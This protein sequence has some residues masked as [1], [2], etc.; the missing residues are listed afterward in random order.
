MLAAWRRVFHPSGNDDT[1]S[2]SSLYNEKC[3]QLEINVTESSPPKATGAIKIE[4]VEAVGG[5]KGRYLLYIGYVLP[6]PY[7]CPIQ[8]PNANHLIPFSLVMLM[9]IL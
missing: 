7:A 2:P 9:V 6:Q 5:R 8:I 1:S 4:A 3:G